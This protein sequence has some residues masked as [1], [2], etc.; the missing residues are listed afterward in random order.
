MSDTAVMRFALKLCEELPQNQYA[1]IS[2]QASSVGFG[3][4]DFEE[5]QDIVGKLRPDICLSYNCADF[6]SNRVG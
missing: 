3:W 5:L 6:S 1:V 2:S 4:L